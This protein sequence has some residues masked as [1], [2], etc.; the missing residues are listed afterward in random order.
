VTMASGAAGAARGASVM[1]DVGVIT[2]GAIAVHK[3]RVLAVGK[4]N[5]IARLFRSTTRIFAHGKTVVPG[6]VDAHTHPAFA[7]WRDEEFAMRCRGASYEEILA[8]GGGILASADA[9]A[10]TSED[11]LVEGLVKTFDSMLC[12]GTTTVEAK[13][14]YGLSP[15]AETKSLRAIRR[16][17]RLVPITVVSTF[18]GA[19]AVP[20]G[21]ER[22]RADYVRLVTDVMI[23][24]VAKG[25][26]ATFC[27]VFCE[28]GAF[29]AA[30]SEK[31]LRAG[32]LNGLRPKVHADEFSDGGG[33]A[34]AARVRAV[35]AEHLGATGPEGIKALAKA[36]VV[37]VLL[38][39]TGLFLRLP[40]KPDARAMVEAGCAVALATD[41]NP[42]SSPTA[43]LALAASLGCSMLGLTPEE[44]L[45]AVTRNA[46]AAIGQDDRAGAMLPGR[47][48]D[49]VLLDAPSYVHLSYRLGTNLVDTVIRR[50]EVV[51]R[52][53]RRVPSA[54]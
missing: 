1:N 20:R 36:R 42:G 33:A 7:R 17:A 31:I 46:A 26:L 44:A 22:R 38:P 14:G 18:L 8:A 3:G 47:P 43:S 9:V 32:V 50:G 15:A 19:H 41:F 25:R 48:A 54:A 27:D 5:E 40:K 16:A 10:A 13:S 35:S 53:G 24:A 52:Q 30:E 12:L 28:R 49:L 11:D 29:T 6:L 21:Y 4:T 34:L 39:T 23:P 37:P 2:E 51:V 45:T